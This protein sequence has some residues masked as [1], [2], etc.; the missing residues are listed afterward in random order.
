MKPQLLKLAP[1]LLSLVGGV[2]VALSFPPWNQDWLIWIGFVP[3][4]AGLLLFPRH[5]L[6]ALIQGAVFAGTFG[7]LVFSWLW[8]GG[9]PSDWVWNVGSLAAVGA[10]WG[11]FVSVFV[12]LPI[13]NSDRKVAP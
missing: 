8:A 4:L 11:V 9:R 3:A 13:G 12:Q 5:W 2:L 7:A 1:F 6:K 10:I